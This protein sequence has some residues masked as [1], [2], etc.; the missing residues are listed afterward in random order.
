MILH[1]LLY[2]LVIIINSTVLIKKVLSHTIVNVPPLMRVYLKVLNTLVHKFLTNQHNF[3]LDDYF[4]P[5][6][7]TALG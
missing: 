3:D 6:G 1:T 5:Q 2:K 4:L 7:K